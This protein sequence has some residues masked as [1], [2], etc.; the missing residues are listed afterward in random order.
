MAHG[1]QLEFVTPDEGSPFK[2]AVPFILKGCVSELAS[3]PYPGCPGGKCFGGDS[4]PRHALCLVHAGHG[5]R[6]A[7]SLLGLHAQGQQR[8]VPCPLALHEQRVPALRGESV[9][10]LGGLGLTVWS[11]MGLVTMGRGV[12]ATCVC[13]STWRASGA[14][15]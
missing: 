5:A 1:W 2:D 10:L 13:R 8:P 7:R 3:L 11:S 14:S 4:K 6:N 12:S 9:G 15:T